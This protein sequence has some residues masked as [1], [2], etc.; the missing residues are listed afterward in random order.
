MHC[1]HICD[2][3][4]ENMHS[5]VGNEIFHFAAAAVFMRNVGPDDISGSHT[6]SL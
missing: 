6:H 5:C 3:S 2:H 4:Q 1:V